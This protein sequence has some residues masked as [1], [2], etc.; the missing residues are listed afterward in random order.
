MAN[1]ERREF[2]KRA[3]LGGVGTML[4]AGATTDEGHA[5]EDRMSIS[6]SASPK[7][8]IIGGAGIAGL[9]C[10]YELMKKGH[11]V[12]VL[13]AAGRYGG[14]VLTVHDG[15]AD[16]LYADFGA[17]NITKPGYQNYWKYVDEFKL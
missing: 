4:L 1:L 17:E 7:K 9:C 10:A 16:G 8:I 14:S 2:I 11:Q 12:L 5:T 13:E 15:L 6:T 3:A